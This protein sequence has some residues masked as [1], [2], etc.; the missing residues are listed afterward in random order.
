MDYSNALNSQLILMFLIIVLGLILKK[1]NFYTDQFIKEL[2]NFLFV[3]INP[4]TIVNSLAIGFSTNK[5]KELGISFALA[6]ASYM[7]SVLFGEL[8]FHKEKYGIE[9]F[10]VVINN[11]GFF[12][13]PIV[14]SLFGTSAIFY[15][16]S[17]IAIN[18]ISQW[19]YGAYVMSRDKNTISLKTIITNT[20]V[21]ATII[22]FIMF[23]AN[24]KMP[25]FA[26]NTISSLTAMMGPICSL[27]IGANL[28]GTS[29]KD[30][31]NDLMNLLVITIRLLI[32]P[33][34]TVYV[35]KCIN[36]EFF[37]LKFT[38]LIMA[39]APT[40]TSTSIF[41]RMYDKDFEKAARLVCACTL[42]CMLSMPFV[43]NIAMKIW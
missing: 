34:L 36:N 15:A 42:L 25:A 6:F 38:L 43:T 35:F 8:V 13:L 40:G 14:I 19:T 5:A 31:M 33:L 30:I 1:V 23:F 17:Y 29:F 21:I 10:G 28:A 12:G 3:V 41:A 11:C 27:I 32:V 9:K 24:I 16:V 26:S 2:G 7:L 39:S 37:A 20:S 18:T 22:G 4:L